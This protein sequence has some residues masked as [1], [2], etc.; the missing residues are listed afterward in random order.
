MT[1]VESLLDIE[2]SNLRSRILEATQRLL[3]ATISITDEQ[4]QQPTLLPGW[5]RAHVAT[6]LASNAD[7]LSQLID[8]IC[9]GIPNP[10]YQLASLDD[11]ERGSERQAL[12]LQ[13]A[14]DTATN[15]LSKNSLRLDNA[16]SQVLVTL[17][18]GNRIKTK[19]LP[20]AHLFEVE[21]HH[22]DLNIG[23]TIDDIPNQVAYWILLWA[24]QKLANDYPELSVQ[25]A[26]MGAPQIEL[27]KFPHESLAGSP[28]ALLGWATGRL[29]KHSLTG[30]LLPSPGLM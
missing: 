6:H 28:Q 29:S 4:W 26:P 20:L 23:Y 8:Q 19:D 14:L 10:C 24:S 7:S 21:I 16:Q 30:S 2:H 12:E 9:D 5:T 22:V 25:L 18:D 17:P 11:L 1:I 13:I 3:G 15:N 27:G